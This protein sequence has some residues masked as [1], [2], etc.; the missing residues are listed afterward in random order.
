MAKIFAPFFGYNRTMMAPDIMRLV[1]EAEEAGFDAAFPGM[2][3][4]EYFLQDARQAVK[5]PVVGPAESAMMVAQLVGRKFAVITNGDAFIPGMEENIR[6]HGWSGR[7][8]AHRPVR[9]WD[10]DVIQLM[11][12]A[13]DGRP[14]QLVEEFDRLAVECVRDGADVVICGC[15]P[16]GAALS[17]VGYNTVAGTGVPVVTALPSMIKMAEALVDLRR[18]VGLTKSEALLGRYRSTPAHVLADLE[19]RSIGM[20]KVAAAPTGSKQSARSELSALEN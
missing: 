11:A 18:N 6:F 20:A 16:Y 10:T 4:G 8:I 14:E 15:N 2:C 17:Q 13:Y 5:I 9:A 7:A 1:K 3:F 12:D 19:D